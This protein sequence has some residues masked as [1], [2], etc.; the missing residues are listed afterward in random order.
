[1]LRCDEGSGQRRSWSLAG[2]VALLGRWARSPRGRGRL[3]VGGPLAAVPPAKAVPTFRVRKPSGGR[4]IG[5]RVG[6]QRG[7]PSLGTTE[8]SRESSA[9]DPRCLRS[10]VCM[11]PC[12][13]Q[14]RSGSQRLVGNRRTRATSDAW[15]GTC[16]PRTGT[17]TLFHS[18]RGRDRQ[19]GGIPKEGSEA[20]L[21]SG[22]FA[23]L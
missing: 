15:R 12:S 14:C 4:Q 17:Q 3:S 22:E 2:S 1:M 19:W 7:S 23:T 21:P 8:I 10:F 6:R 9:R 20:I 16:P 11:P 5:G 18:L 13:A